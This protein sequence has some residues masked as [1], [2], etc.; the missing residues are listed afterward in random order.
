MPYLS[1][2]GDLPPKGKEGELSVQVGDSL[3]QI[4]IQ[5]LIPIVSDKTLPR[6]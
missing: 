5:F 1:I 4:I 6:S 2:C 3:M